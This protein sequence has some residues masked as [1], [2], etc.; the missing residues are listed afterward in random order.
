[1]NNSRAGINLGSV[2]EWTLISFVRIHGVIESITGVVGQDGCP[3]MFLL[4]F[5]PAHAHRWNGLQ[6]LPHQIAGYGLRFKLGPEAFGLVIVQKHIAF[7]KPAGDTE[8][9]FFAT[10]IAGVD[11]PRLGQRSERDHQRLAAHG[12]VDRLMPIEDF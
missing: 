5:L 8:S 1:M 11:H 10:D 7:I 12:I 6:V 4:P 9:Q 2:C 3:G